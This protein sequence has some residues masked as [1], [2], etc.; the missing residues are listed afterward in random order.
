MLV[1]QCRS[2]EATGPA[3]LRDSLAGDFFAI[4]LPA[5]DG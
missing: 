2:G 1:E 4:V 5:L 3:V